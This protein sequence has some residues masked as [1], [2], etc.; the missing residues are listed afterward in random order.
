MEESFLNFYKILEFFLAKYKSG[1][2]VG[3]LIEE[4]DIKDY[5]IAKRL[6]ESFVKIR[7]NYDIAHTRI[8]RIKR[9]SIENRDEFFNLS[10]Y[11]NFWEKYYD[12]KDFV[13]Y[14]ILRYVNIKKL[15]FYIGKL[16]SL[17]IKVRD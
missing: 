17:D 15:D 9:D 11:D 8:K 6:I 12:I 16:N 10:F 7:N 5:S 2:S 14:L 1:N 4:Y 13:K 3:K